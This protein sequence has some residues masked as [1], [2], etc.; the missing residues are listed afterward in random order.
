MAY[1]DRT[2]QHRLESHPRPCTETRR[3]ANPK[4]FTA[5]STP[6]HSVNYSGSR[7]PKPESLLTV[8]EL[9]A[10]IGKTPKAVYDLRYRGVPGVLPLSIEVGGSI[11]YDPADVRE[12]LD[13]QRDRSRQGQ[14]DR[15]AAS[16]AI[17]SRPRTRPLQPVRKRV[18][19]QVSLPVPREES[20]DSEPCSCE[21]W[22]RATC[23]TCSTVTGNR[24]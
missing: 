5:R 2:L 19:V 1:Q 8:D 6:G 22:G 14:H 12:W 21:L 7:M 17:K 10:W 3:D 15:A 20:K 16:R 4:A 24:P 23:S 13:G 18:R 9:A 11:R